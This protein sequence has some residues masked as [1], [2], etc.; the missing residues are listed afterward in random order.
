MSDAVLDASAVIALVYREPGAEIVRPTVP[1]A[2]ISTVNLS[3]A[4]AKLSNDG[5]SESAIRRTFEPYEWDIVRFDE[6]QAYAAG[7]LRPLTRAAG[8]SLGDRACIVLGQVLGLPV[9]TTDR[10]WARLDLDV[11]V[12]LIR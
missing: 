3:E 10:A 5:M 11:E 6:R 2:S 7:L 4:V 8:L 1:S 12:R 9:L